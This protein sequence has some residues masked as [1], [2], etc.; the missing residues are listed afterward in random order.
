MEIGEARHVEACH[1]A[2]QQNGG[3]KICY[4]QKTEPNL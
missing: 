1:G 2:P 4:S 3:K